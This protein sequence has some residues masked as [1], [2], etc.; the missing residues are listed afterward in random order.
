MRQ[1]MKELLYS[2]LVAF[3]VVVLNSQASESA[4]TVVYCHQDNQLDVL[5]NNANQLIQQTQLLKNN[6]DVLQQAVVDQN[7]TIGQLKK[8]AV[9]CKT[10]TSVNDCTSFQTTSP[11]AVTVRDCY[12]IQQQNPTAQNGVYWIKPTSYVTPF[13]VYCQLTQY[14]GGWTL[15]QRRLDGSQLFFRPWYDYANGFGNLLTEFWMGND[16]L[17]AMTAGRQY[18]LRVDLTDWSGNSSYAEY[19]FFR[20]SDSKD[21]YRLTGLTYRTG[22]AGD[23]LTS[24]HFNQQFSTFDQDNDAYPT[25]NV[26]YGCLSAWWFG[27]GAYS[28]LNGW[29]NGTTYNTG[30]MNEITWNS[31][32]PVRHIRYA[33]MKIRPA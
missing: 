3:F 13:Q 27:N 7:A 26:A 4:D 21:K 1:G 22:T 14:G 5:Q 6:I 8:N 23:A 24:I 33:E 11:A 25:G 17:A 9:Q 16:R 32:K 30:W 28:H 2:A 12:D 18:S 10:T 20:I 29:Y 19:S 31:W 15:F